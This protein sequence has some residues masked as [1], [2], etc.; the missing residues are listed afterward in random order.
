MPSYLDIAADIARE[1]GALLA[2]Y[3]DRRVAFELNR[4]HYLVTDS[5][6]PPPS[7]RQRPLQLTACDADAARPTGRLACAGSGV[8]G[9]R[10]AGRFFG[11]R[12]EPLGPGGRA[13]AWH[14]GGSP[15]LGH[16]GWPG[17]A[18]RSA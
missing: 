8:R 3:F 9:M 13:S 1:S 7:E 11:I 18:A 16:G 10:A 12:S 17:E 14:R 4:E 5:P 6:P 15:V 2:N